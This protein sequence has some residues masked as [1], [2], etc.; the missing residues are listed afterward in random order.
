MCITGNAAEGGG[1]QR[2]AAGEHPVR[3]SIRV[4]VDGGAVCAEPGRWAEVKGTFRL[5][6][7]PRGAAVH[8]HGAP[9][10]VDVK[11]MDL[12]IIATDRKARFSHLKE[13]GGQGEQPTSRNHHKPAGF[14]HVHRLSIYT[15]TVS[16]SI[17]VLNF[18][19]STN[20]SSAGRPSVCIHDTISQGKLRTSGSKTVHGRV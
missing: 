7:S 11:V 5:S 15:Y 12:R 2:A 6:E 18:F 14:D 16:L 3:V 17:Y 8:V 4:G 10:G 9:A 19:L 1:Q 20:F 13:K